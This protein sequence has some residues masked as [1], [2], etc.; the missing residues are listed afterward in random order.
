[1][2]YDDD[3]LPEALVQKRFFALPAEQQ[4]FFGLYLAKLVAGRIMREPG[5]AAVRIALEAAEKNA[6]V[7]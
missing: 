2:I 1:M 4:Q 7:E 6:R 5:P 3:A